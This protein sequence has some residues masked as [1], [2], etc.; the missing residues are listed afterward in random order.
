MIALVER[1]VNVV[2]TGPNEGLAKELVTPHN[3]FRFLREE[4]GNGL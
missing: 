1:V 4:Y 2:L 3:N